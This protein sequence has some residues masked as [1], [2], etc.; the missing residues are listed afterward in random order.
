MKPI[1]DLELDPWMSASQVADYFGV[2]KC[3]LY[4]WVKDKIFPPPE[5]IGHRTKRWR[6]SVVKKHKL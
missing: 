5:K 3:T 4:R 1:S 2:K 6:M